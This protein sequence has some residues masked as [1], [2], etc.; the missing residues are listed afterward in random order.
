MHKLNSIMCNKKKDLE[1][2]KSKRGFTLVELM[3][4]IAIIGILFVILIPKLS[5]AMTKSREAGVKN[6]FR[7]MNL[8]AE[9][10]M[11]ENSGMRGFGSVDNLLGEA[12]D[13]TTNLNIYLDDALKFDYSAE[14][15]C[16]ICRT[17]DPWNLPYEVYCAN[18]SGQNNNG[19][20]L[21][22]SGGTEGKI[23]G[24]EDD[25][26]SQEDGADYV[27]ATTWYDGTISTAT[28]GFSKNIEAAALN[29][30]NI[31]DDTSTS[32][33]VDSGTG[34]QTVT[35]APSNNSVDD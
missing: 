12:G 31:S 26:Q 21:F 10:L 34:A 32:M 28:T 18:M 8:A 1:K 24:T 33:T 3:I 19:V 17:E 22:V 9:Q 16:G 11:R 6:D 14:D 13:A 7:S 35:Y 4:V 27:L 15:S 29:H 20:I 2:K 5:T 25:D 23:A 30:E